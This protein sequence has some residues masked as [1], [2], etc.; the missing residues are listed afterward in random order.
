MPKPTKREMFE[1][2]KPVAENFP[3]PE[4]TTCVEVR[5]P[6]DLEYLYLLQGFMAKMTDYWTWTGTTAQRKERAAIC[7]KAYVETEWGGCMNCDELTA[8]ITPLL[9]AMRDNI[10]N[11]ITNMNEYG[12]ENPGQPMSEADRTENLPGA[13]NPEC[14][15]DILWAQCLAIVQWTNRAATDLME[16]LEVVTNAAEALD[17]ITDAP[18]VNLVV[19]QFGVE[20]A[21]GLVNY[22][23]DSAR[24]TYTAQ[25]TEDVEYALACQLFCEAMLDCGLSVDRIYNTFYA[26]V[27]AEIPDSPDDM[28][29]FLVTLAGLNPVTDNVVDLMFWF[30]WA[31]AKLMSVVVTKVIGN[32]FD[33]NQLLQLAVSEADNDWVL[34]CEEC[35]DLTYGTPVIDE[36]GNCSSPIFG[37]S[38][39]TSLGDGFW[40]ITNTLESDMAYWVVFK[41]ASDRDFFIEGITYPDGT[42]STCRVYQDVT[43][44]CLIECIDDADPS[45]V[46]SNYGVVWSVGAQRIRFRMIAHI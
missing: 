21:E 13:T 38:T 30:A 12:I 27:V 2:D 26:N 33:L 4:D 25:Y 19:D 6:N 15:K 1:L 24:E 45:P 22:L 10:V 32:N 9:E 31:G 23:A 17:I 5:I 46:V 35:T 20:S 14:N 42:P 39:I 43:E 28:L 3:V 11:S 44:G 34:L 41:D 7:L 16:R 8:C 18:V 37:G 29:E 40:E 36:A